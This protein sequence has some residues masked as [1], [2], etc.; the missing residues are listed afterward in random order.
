M[1][2]HAIN[3]LTRG[4]WIFPVEPGG[5]MPHRIVPDKEYRVRW[6][7][8]ATNNLAKVVEWWRCSPEANLGLAAKPSGLLILDSD[9][10]KEPDILKG[11][12]WAYL[13]DSLGPWLD[14]DD[15]L[16]AMC[17]RFDQSWDELQATYR[18]CT[19]SGGAHRYFR[20]PE[21]VHAS[22]ASPVPG[23]LDARGNGGQRGGYVLGAGSRTEKGEY[24]VENDTPIADCPPWLVE[25]CREKPRPARVK[26]LFSQPSG[27]GGLNGL[28]D[29]V[30]HAGA[31]NVNHC[32]YWSASVMRDD[33]I[34]EEKCVEHL[35]EVYA[36]AG[37]RGGE[38]QAMQTIRSAYR[39][40]GAG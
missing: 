14:G 40:L 18:V 6:G 28:I 19:A 16:R 8:V 34:P 7:E 13:H 21:G 2:P 23:L 4:F 38:R 9:I 24:V 31:G 15:I 32:L 29:A 36:E 27:G 39:S 37:G 30:R 25:L 26:P 1:L 33:G 17:D 5:K 35:A 12:T 11:G 3:A 20:W 22:Q 10:A